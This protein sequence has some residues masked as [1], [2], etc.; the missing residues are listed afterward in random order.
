MRRRRQF[1]IFSKKLLA[2]MKIK[3]FN[4]LH[5]LKH[6]LSRSERWGNKQR[7]IENKRPVA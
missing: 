6:F 5:N 2:K 1:L 7:D 4:E 3:I